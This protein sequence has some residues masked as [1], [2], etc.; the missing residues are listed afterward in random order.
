MIVHCLLNCNGSIN[1]AQDKGPRTPHHLTGSGQ[2]KVHTARYGSRYGTES[3]PK[4]K[5]PAK[6]KDFSLRS[7]I[8]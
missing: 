4:Y 7:L 6:V 8:T 2:D 3:V 5:I 1:F